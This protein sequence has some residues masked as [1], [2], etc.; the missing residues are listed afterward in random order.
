MSDVATAEDRDPATPF[1]NAVN[2]VQNPTLHVEDYTY[3]I[4]GDKPRDNEPSSTTVTIRGITRTAALLTHTFLSLQ[5]EHFHPI[6]ILVD[7]FALSTA[8]Y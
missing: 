4:L 2:S 3:E 6:I 1:I 5:T 7:R 8:L